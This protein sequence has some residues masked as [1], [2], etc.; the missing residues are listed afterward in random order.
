[1]TPVSTQRSIHPFRYWAGWVGWVLLIFSFTLNFIPLPPDAVGMMVVGLALVGLLVLAPIPLLIRYWEPLGTIPMV[2][3]LVA[4]QWA[5]T[6]FS[7]LRD[8]P[9]LLTTL[10]NVATLYRVFEAVLL[11]GAMLSL[12]LKRDVSRPLFALMMVGMSY[13]LITMARDAGSTNKLL[14]DIARSMQDTTQAPPY[15]PAAET[16]FCLAYIIVPLSLF[17]ILLYLS[18]ALLWEVKQL[19]PPT[20]QSPA[21]PQ[22][23]P[24]STAPTTRTRELVASLFSEEDS[25]FLDAVQLLGASYPPGLGFPHAYVMPFSQP[26]TALGAGDPMDPDLAAILAVTQVGETL[27][28]RF[29]STFDLHEPQVRLAAQELLHSHLQA[30]HVPVNRQAELVNR[31]LAQSS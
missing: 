2:I 30:A 26:L 9:P 14:L 4:L 27:S 23:E 8:T 22:I 28:T 10:V 31:F 25:T 1:M 20:L 5:L 29:G 11:A 21:A 17:G 6:A 24:A 16:M 15:T 3:A 19:N 12:V 13:A 18:R 7:G